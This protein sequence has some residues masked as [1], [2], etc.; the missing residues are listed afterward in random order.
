MKLPKRH[1]RTARPEASGPSDPSLPRFCRETRS[2]LPAL[3][4][5]EL[6]GWPLHVVRAH[7]K[8][9]A[10]CAAEQLRQEQLSSALA[11]LKEA[12]PAPPPHLL[13]KLLARADNRGVRER[14]AVPA[15]G[16]LSGARPGLSVAFLTVGAAASTGVGYGV[17]RGVKALRGRGKG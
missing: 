2:Q 10:D 4:R 15:R 6:S 7:L 12:P 16:A 11:S 17:Y 9:C 5:G 13:D 14:A 3:A 8:R 1:P